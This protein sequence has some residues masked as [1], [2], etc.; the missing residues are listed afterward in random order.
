MTALDDPRILP[1]MDR[2][3]AL[4]ERGGGGTAPNP[5]VGCVLADGAGRILGEGFHERAGGPHAEV[6][7]IEAART[8]GHEVRGATAVVTLEPCAHQG[9]TRPCVGVLLDAGIARV[10]YAMSDPHEGK[11]GAARLAAAGVSVAGGVREAEAQRLNE[12]WLH[13]IETGRPFYHLKTAQTLNARVTRGREDV[14]WVTGSWARAAVHRLRRRYAAVLVG[15]GTVL[16]D[17]P[18]LTVRAWPDEGN[19]DGE[20]LWPDFQPARV[21]LDS[22]LGT[23]VSSRLLST[24]DSAPV[25]IFCGPEASE[26]RASE[27]A[28]RGADIVRVPHIPAGLDMESVSRELATRGITGVL[29]EPGPTLATSLLESRIV[30]R[31]TMFLA[32]EWVT[33]RGAQPLL[34]TDAPHTGFALEGAEWEIHGRDASVSG[35]V[36]FTP[37]AAAPAIPSSS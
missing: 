12:P 1:L 25:W 29:V 35:R 30:D 17:D 23:P 19:G 5:M 31:W 24:A 8:S 13:S 16:A 34:L 32:P 36:R 11:G 28:A 33:A 4:A 26:A 6:A 21:I 3:L 14:R 37:G 27:L 7:A 20:P 10:I 22:S 9:R 15:V 18:L 2:A